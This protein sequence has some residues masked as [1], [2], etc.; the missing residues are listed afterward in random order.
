MVLKPF[1]LLFLFID[2]FIPFGVTGR[3][4]KPIPAVHWWSQALCENFGVQC[5]AQ[6]LVVLLMCVFIQ[7]NSHNRAT[8][9][10]NITAEKV[11]NCHINCDGFVL[12][13]PYGEVGGL[14]RDLGQI[15]GCDD[16]AV[17]KI[18]LC[19]STNQPSTHLISL[20]W[21]PGFDTDFT[22]DVIHS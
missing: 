1:S 19:T 21:K 11:S 7:L 15:T 18:I 5:L 2:W 8:I 16:T 9:F 12:L 3:M 20:V 22:I 4:L 13:C 6:G 17:W 14:V 10:R